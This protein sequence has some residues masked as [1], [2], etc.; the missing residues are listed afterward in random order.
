MRSICVARG[1]CA[2][3]GWFFLKVFVFASLAFFMA[4]LAWA[5]SRDVQSRGN[6]QR[7]AQKQA[8]GKRGPQLAQSSPYRGSP[9]SYGYRRRHQ[10]VPI[11][12]LKTDKGP[13]RLTSSASEPNTDRPP[14]RWEEYSIRPFELSIV[15]PVNIFHPKK[16]VIIG[17]SL[18]VPYGK[19]NSA[20]GLEI[21]VALNRETEDFGGIQLAVGGNW[22]HRDAYGLQ[23]AGILNWME[24]HMYGI[25]IAGAV[26]KSKGA[27]FGFCFAGFFQWH[28]WL[29]G[30]QIAGGMNGVLEEGKGIQIGS[31]NASQG[32][33]SGIQISPVFNM[34]TRGFHGFQLSSVNWNSTSWFGTG[35]DRMRVTYKDDS[36][37]IQLGV[38]FNSVYGFTGL[39]ISGFMNGTDGYLN[40]FQLAPM[41]FS[42]DVNGV[43]LGVLN[44]AEDVKGI[45]IGVLNICSRLKGL[46]IGVINVA[47]KNKLP[48]MVGLLAGF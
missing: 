42:D 46:Q 17:L 39:Q 33:F 27:C 5:G 16:K 18:N 13:M 34:V 44:T 2:R 11:S 36:S 45:Q 3:Q 29:R 28:K 48:F 35:V 14:R 26:N 7:N 19:A 25:Q 6:A 30:I 43:Q 8:T 32:W 24:G 41:N 40:G 20:Y 12:R 31:A 38:M 10:Y 15:P 1:P 47:T 21:G 9:Y 22:V 37:G 23:I 4:P